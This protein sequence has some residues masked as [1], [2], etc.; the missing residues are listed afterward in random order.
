MALTEWRGE[1]LVQR[2]LGLV[3]R[4][5]PLHVSIAGGEPLIRYRELTCVIRQ[6]NTMGIEVQVVTS[7]VRPIPAEWTEFPNLHLVVSVDGL[8]PE[9]DARRTPATYDRILVKLRTAL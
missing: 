4:F 8:Q 3:R 5:R 9:H 7:A 6:L 1:E 2:V